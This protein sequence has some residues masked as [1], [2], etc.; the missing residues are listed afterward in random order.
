MISQR[1]AYLLRARTLADKNDYDRALADVDT[2]LKA[3]ARN[4][5]ALGLRAGIF[6]RQGDCARAIADFDA[7]IAI[8]AKAWDGYVGRAQC[9]ATLGER[10]RAAADYRAALAGGAPDA[11]KPQILEELQKLGAAP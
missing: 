1:N 4:I 6:A 9:Y 5:R 7:V 3:D 11:V 10:D 2:L 8:D